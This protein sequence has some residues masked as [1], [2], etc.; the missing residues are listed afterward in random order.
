[1]ELARLAP[2]RKKNFAIQIVNFD[3]A[4][5]CFTEK[6]NLMYTRIDQRHVSKLLEHLGLV[7]NHYGKIYL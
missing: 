4:I 7:K 1:M 5:E 2:L 6:G 3:G